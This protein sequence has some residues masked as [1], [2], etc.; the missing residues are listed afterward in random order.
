MHK[1][2]KTD[3]IKLEIKEKRR[4]TFRIKILPQE[5]DQITRTIFYF[6][7]IGKEFVTRWRHLYDSKQFPM[8]RLISLSLS[9]EQ[10]EYSLVHC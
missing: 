7:T 1:I 6:S 10:I 3:T 5:T 8:E 2:H 9:G 4:L